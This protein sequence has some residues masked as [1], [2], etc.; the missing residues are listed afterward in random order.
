VTIETK[1]SSIV[2]FIVGIFLTTSIVAQSP[3]EIPPDSLPSDRE[4]AEGLDGDELVEFIQTTC[5]DGCHSSTA[6]MFGEVIEENYDSSP[7]G[8]YPSVDGGPFGGGAAI[9]TDDDND[10]HL[11]FSESGDG[12]CIEYGSGEAPDFE[13]PELPGGGDGLEP[14]DFVPLYLQARD[15]VTAG[16]SLSVDSEI[17][18]VGGED[19]E[20]TVELWVEGEGVVDSTNL[21]LNA[22]QSKSVSF[23]W[24][25]DTGDT[26]DRLI[27]F[28]AD[29]NVNDGTPSMN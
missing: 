24:N 18:N 3:P 7:G 10:N 28:R 8:R 17:K 14:G 1:K 9:L 22:D 27:E 26:G 25:T 16:Y 5:G 11:C 4:I 2:L 21:D 12:D 23:E 20:R 19:R 13:V 29:F 6:E 15:S